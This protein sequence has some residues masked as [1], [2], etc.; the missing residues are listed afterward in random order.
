MRPLRRRAVFGVTALTAVTA[1][2]S[3]AAG[4][5]AAMPSAQA[6]GSSFQIGLIGDTGY[7][8][9][10]DADLL[11]VRASM[12][13]SGLAFEVH[14]GDIQQQGSPCTDSRLQYV[15]GVFDGFA[16]PFGDLDVQLRER[17]IALRGV[18]EGGHQPREWLVGQEG[19]QPGDHI[20]QVTPQLSG[21]GQREGLA[22]DGRGHRITKI[23]I[24]AKAG[25]HRSAF[26][27]SGMWIPAF[28]GLTIFLM[29]IDG[30]TKRAPAT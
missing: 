13:G 11:A 22:A 3:T 6:A 26:E 28:A 15:R 30:I 7:S 27:S 14:D 10:L 4:L 18:D 25:I 23:V 19:L 16:A 24:P 2:L 8:A 20:D 21:R 9:G 5:G 29:A 17:R 1:L 12:A